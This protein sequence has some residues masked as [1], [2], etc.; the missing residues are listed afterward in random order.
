M[1]AQTGRTVDKFTYFIVADSNDTLREIPVKTV[2]DV[3]LDYDAVDVTAMQDAI[4]NSLSGQ[5]GAPI[6]ITVPFDNSASVTCPA[7]G[8]AHALSGPHG[9]LTGICGDNKP[10][11]LQIRFGVRHAWET[12]EPV[13]GLQRATASNSGYTCTKYTKSGEEASATFEVMGGIA[14]AWGT[15]ALTAGS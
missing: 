5:P 14:P 13:F 4:K 12:G 1:A 15:A 11:T 8:E 10:H 7:S 9:V 3:G 2:G 6:T